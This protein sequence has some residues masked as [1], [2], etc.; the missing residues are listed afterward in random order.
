[1]DSQKHSPKNQLPTSNYL[2]AAIKKLPKAAPTMSPQTV[3]IDAGPAGRYRV[4][5]VVRQ[6]AG[7]RTPVWFWGVDGGEQLTGWRAGADDPA[8]QDSGWRYGPLFSEM[9]SE[10]RLRDWRLEAEGR[11]SWTPETPDS[12][13]NT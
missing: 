1:M 6:K 8:R 3:A 13:N 4:T 10:V 7:R 11:N 5:F 2:A 12:A 9:A